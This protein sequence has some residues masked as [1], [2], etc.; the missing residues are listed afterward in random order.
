MSSVYTP[1]DWQQQVHSLKADEILGAG[2][3]GVGKTRCLLAD[4]LQQ[5]IVEHQRATDPDH[6][7]PIG[8]GRST[9]WAIHLRRQLTDLTQTINLSR[10]FFKSID[11]GAKFDATDNIWTFSSG[12][13]FQFGHCKDEGDFEKYLSLEFCLAEGQRVVMA[14]GSLRAIENVSAGDLVMTLE[15]PKRV[16]ATWDTGVKHCAALD[17]LHP[18]TGDPIGTQIHPTTH[19]VLLSSIG[20]SQCVS[21]HR[22]RQSAAR[23]LGH[24]VYWQDY[25]SRLCGDRVILEKRVS[26]IDE[27]NCFVASDGERQE[28]WR[29]PRLSCRLALHERTLREALRRASSVCAS[30][31]GCFSSCSRSRQESL[32]I[33]ESTETDL[34]REHECDLQAQDCLPGI[35]ACGVEDARSGPETAK[36]STDHCFACSRPRGEQPLLGGAPGQEQSQ[37]EACAATHSPT[38]RTHD[39]LARILEC[40]QVESSSYQHFYSGDVRS[41]KEG[42]CIAAGEMRYAGMRRTYDLT[43]EDANHYIGE[44]GIVNLQTHIGYDE[45]RTFTVDQY[46]GINARLRSSDPVLKHMLRIIGMSNPGPSPGRD[47]QWVRKRFVDPCPEGRRLIREKFFLKSGDPFYRTRVYWPG[48][49]DDNPDPEFKLVYEKNLQAKSLFI[50]EAYLN[51]NWYFTPGA[52]FGEDFDP[53][54][55]VISKFKIPEDWPVFRMMDWGFK[56]KGACYWGALDPDDNLIIF[57]ELVFQ[58]RHDNVVAQDIKRIEKRHGYWGMNGRSRITG[59]ADTQLWE[60]RGDSAKRKVDVF[61]D[62][63]V[64]WVQADKRSRQDNAERVLKRLQDHKGGTQ[65][66]GLMFMSNCKYAISTI[67]QLPT[68]KLNPEEPEKGGEDHGYD[69]ISYGVAYASQAGRVQVANDDDDFEDE[70][71]DKPASRGRWGYGS[72]VA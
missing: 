2:A 33:P 47:P 10:S 60:E 63:G 17:V 12:Y 59:P 8:L 66:P 46:E 26:A 50:R 39:C 48:K 30:S 24:E 6:P 25:E 7:Y 20:E 4:P 11:P 70:D 29:L 67:P 18:T 35:G 53:N 5:I 15:G 57:E 40:S 69:A 72:E 41:L 34:R 68:S 42:V 55:H 14:D 32:Q 43:V 22:K 1:S 37:H 62:L 31:T 51:G 54:I 19:P 49:L 9:G 71:D 38:C 45:L 61:N 58:G 44:F 23:C 3:A 27:E 36:D 21:S 56:Q 52:F 28:V 65:A 16:L 64:S 13:H